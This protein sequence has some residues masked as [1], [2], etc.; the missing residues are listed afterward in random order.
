MQN[1]VVHSF[2]S[3]R[4]CSECIAPLAPASDCMSH[5]PASIHALVPA[6][7][8]PHIDGQ[9]TALRPFSTSEEERRRRA[10]SM[11][12]TSLSCQGS[13]STDA[14]VHTSEPERATHP[15]HSMCCGSTTSTEKGENPWLKTHTFVRQQHAKKVILVLPKPFPRRS[16][17]RRTNSLSSVSPG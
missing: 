11:H 3:L 10:T 7:C 16:K 17:A 5:Q 9:T 8:A 13:Q 12:C 15:T 14:T 2:M 6:R 4:A 1:K